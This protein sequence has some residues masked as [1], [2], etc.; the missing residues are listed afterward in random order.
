[1][2]D[3]AWMSIL[4][5]A[6]GALLLTAI[7][8]VWR[9]D[10]PAV[11]VLLGVQGVALA[12]IVGA[13]AALRRDAVL[14]GVAVVLLALR[15]VVLPWLLHRALGSDPGERRESRPL[16]NTPASLL[17]AAVLIGTAFAVTRPVVALDPSAAVRAAPTGMA[18][19]F[20]ALLIMITRR[21]ALS[22]AAGFLM[23]DNGIA[24]TAFLLTAGVPLIVELGA[25]LDVLFAVLVL[26]VLTGWLR[27]TLGSTEVDSLRELGDR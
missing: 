4:S 22:Q 20:I 8:V 2:T 11:T 26:G 25:S 24:A 3:G 6:A 17:A 19:V 10:L 1:M 14:V 7:V 23:L 21:R 16:L 18:V 9:R 5:L 12:I 13:Q 15:G 27:R